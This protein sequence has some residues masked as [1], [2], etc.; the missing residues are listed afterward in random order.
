M[1]GDISLRKLCARRCEKS[2]PDSANFISDWAKAVLI[3]NYG[4][5]AFALRVRH[6]LIGF[7]L[8]DAFPKVGHSAAPN[9]AELGR[10]RKSS[11]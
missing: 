7:S 4:E 8:N 6:C 3:R 1:A 11:A 10:N 9:Q 2:L 5:Y